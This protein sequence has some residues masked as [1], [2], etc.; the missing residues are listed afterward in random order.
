MRGNVLATQGKM[1]RPFSTTTSRLRS[2]PTRTQHL[3]RKARWTARLPI[4]FKP[5]TFVAAA[6]S[7]SLTG[8]FRDAVAGLCSGEGV[9]RS[10][11]LQSDLEHSGA[12]QCRLA[13][14]DQRIW[15]PER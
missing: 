11:E 13:R 14:C 5:T 3:R 12:A 1:R 2:E 10:L 8:N 9:S 15:T 4:A 6:A 7:L